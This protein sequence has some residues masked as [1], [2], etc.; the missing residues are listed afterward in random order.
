VE[1]LLGVLGELLEEE[2]EKGVDILASR[3][4]VADGLAAVGV[5]DIDGLVEEDDG[6]VTVP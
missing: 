5:A 6:S 2:G 1:V 4:G 3:P